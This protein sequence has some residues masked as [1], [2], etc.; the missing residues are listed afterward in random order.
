MMQLY[1]QVFIKT[2][3]SIPNVPFQMGPLVITIIIILETPT[4][5]KV[6][7]SYYKYREV[8]HRILST[9]VK[10]LFG[11][12]VLVQKDYVPKQD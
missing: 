1:P 9:K 8:Y 6:L 5:C 4:L 10:S 12:I 7:Q 11:E 3:F 2:V